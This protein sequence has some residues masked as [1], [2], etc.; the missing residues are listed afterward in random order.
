MKNDILLYININKLF[1]FLSFKKIKSTKLE[2]NKV[3]NP[4]T[5]AFSQYTYI[6]S[7][8]MLLPCLVIALVRTWLINNVCM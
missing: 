7:Q 8:I 2:D 6:F 3:W 5:S 4:Q 1:Y